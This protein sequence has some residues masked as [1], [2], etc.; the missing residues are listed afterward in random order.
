MGGLDKALLTIRGETLLARIL[1]RPR[2]ET[3]LLA[4]SANGDPA[5]FAETGIPVLP[6]RD[7]IG[8]GPLAGLL[9]SLD[10]VAAARAE[11][12]LTVPG[13][14]PFLPAG[15]A[16]DLTPAPSCA[17]S[18]D[19]VHHLVALWPVTARAA[20][21]AHPV[22]GGT[23]AVAAFAAKLGMRVVA[24][25]DRPCDRFLNINTPEDLQAAWVIA[26]NGA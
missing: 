13:D 12:L 17:A 6:D 18:G 7:F 25:P 21:R 26:E 9:A 22:A 24:F 1:Q 19:R 4:I 2:M 14:T 15:L 3:A 11:K 16:A 10:W 20:L 23:R 5:R 8:A